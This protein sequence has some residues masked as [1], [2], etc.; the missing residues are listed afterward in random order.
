[1]P[2]YAIETTHLRKEFGRKV[3]VADL[4]LQIKRGEVFGFRP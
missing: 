1:M 3:A 2:D 4:T